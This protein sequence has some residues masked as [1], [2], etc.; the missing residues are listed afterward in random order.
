MTKEELRNL[1]KE[2]D[3]TYHEVW[4]MLASIKS[5][6]SSRF[7]LEL[8]PMLTCAMAKLSDAYRRIAQRR[9]YLIRHKPRFNPHWFRIQQRRL[10]SRQH[11]I[12]NALAIGRVL[13]DSFAW[14]FY[15]N[16]HE[17]LD[18][19][20]S[21]RITEFIPPGVGGKGEREFVKRVPAV[22]GAYLIYHGIT[23][24]LRMGDVSLFDLN[25]MKICGI[26]ELKTSHIDVNSGTIHLAVLLKKEFA[27]VLKPPEIKQS[28]NNRQSQRSEMT[29]KQRSRLR[30]Q[31]RRITRVVDANPLPDRKIEVQQDHTD[32]MVAF[33]EFV[34]RALANGV[35]YQQ[36]GKGLLYTAV[37]QRVRGLFK[38][39]SPAPDFDIKTV[40]PDLEKY[41]IAICHPT[42]KELNSLEINSFLYREKGHVRF[43]PGSPP[44]FWW[45]VKPHLLRSIV[46]GEVL[47]TTIFNPAHLIEALEGYGF[48]VEIG[49]DHRIKS[50]RVRLTDGK[51]TAE[52][53]GFWYYVELIQI[54]LFTEDQ[55]ALMLK[56][57]AQTLLDEK[58]SDYIHVPVRVQQFWGTLRE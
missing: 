21:H 51:R 15:Q 57:L 47:I 16:D 43:L 32:N 35:A 3:I 49:E 26:G 44:L 56:R 42:R 40:F 41:V 27:S 8:Q 53:A 29:Q 7:V 13:G 37:K 31:M 46:F 14:F 12:R 54:S 11:L 28:S 1:L 52:L 10:A 48:S 4:V 50:L 24:M 58:S 25:K 38:R 33:R 30:K 19:H 36:F 20:R 45:P 5:G 6:R 55:L 17:L 39:L 9:K 18:L 23:S 22:G 2:V 34:T